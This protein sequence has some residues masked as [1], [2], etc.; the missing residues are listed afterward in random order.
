MFDVSTTART[1]DATHLHP[2]HDP[3]DRAAIAYT[4]PERRGGAARTQHWLAATLDE[5]DYG[6]LLLRDGSY[7][8]HVNRTARIELDDGDHPLQ[9]LGR[10]LR[11]R[12]PHDVV[13]LADALGGAARRGLRRLLTLGTDHHRASVSVVPLPSAEGADGPITLVMFGKRQVCEQLSVQGYARSHGLT[14][15]EARVLSALCSGMT[16]N[17]VAKHLGVAIS[18]VR[19]Q[20]GMI[21]MKTGT[22]SLRGLVRQV[23]VLP[24]LM[25]ILRGN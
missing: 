20:I 11:A 9:L 15:A 13:A 6:M 4:G 19:T 18:T 7:A 23:A 17:D 24:P 22:E 3:G 25:G 10:E 16:P 2:P 14:G 21:R 1:S 5:I 8:T 12:Q